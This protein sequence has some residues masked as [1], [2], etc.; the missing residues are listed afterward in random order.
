MVALNV[1]SNWKP[2][3][4]HGLSAER[5]NDICPVFAQCFYYTLVNVWATAVFPQQWHGAIMKVLHKTN[6]Q[7]DCNNYRGSS[8]FTLARK[9]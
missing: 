7:T 9:T 6:D 2:V 8:L 4:S 1:T 5:L 3:G